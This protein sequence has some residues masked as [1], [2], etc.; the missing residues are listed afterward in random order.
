MNTMGI[1]VLRDYVGHPLVTWEW[2]RYDSLVSV[3]GSADYRVPYYNIQSLSI[4]ITQTSLVA[5]VR[6]IHQK[7]I[8]LHAMH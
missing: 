2:G 7:K 4:I 1:W 3:I 6:D 8:A 5:M